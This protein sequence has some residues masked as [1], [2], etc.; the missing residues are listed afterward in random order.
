MATR[1]TQNMHAFSVSSTLP[2]PHCVHQPPIPPDP[3]AYHIHAW[4]HT[5]I[6]GFKTSRPIWDTVFI[7]D[8][9]PHLYLGITKTL[10][11]S[12]TFFILIPC[13]RLALLCMTLDSKLKTNRDTDL[14]RFFFL[15]CC[16]QHPLQSF[17]AS[18]TVCQLI[19][20]LWKDCYWEQLWWW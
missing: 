19:M 10:T 1:C 11:F 14:V 7:W 13:T 17:Q 20:D 2:L 4:Q 15:S 18:L 6:Q 16:P 3:T 8:L 9:A 12:A 5:L